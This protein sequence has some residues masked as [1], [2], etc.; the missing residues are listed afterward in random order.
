MSDKID[1]F[2]LPGAW[3]SGT[4]F[5]FMVSVFS[6]HPKV[7]KIHVLNYDFLSEEIPSVTDRAIKLLQDINN[8]AVVVGH[9]LGGIIALNIS[10][11]ENVQGILTISSPLAGIKMNPLIMIYLNHY[12]PKFNEIVEKSNI[13]KDIHNKEYTKPM[14]MLVSTVGFNPFIFEPNDGIVT[15]ISQTKWKPENA[16]MKMIGASHHEILQHSDTIVEL[17]RL[18]H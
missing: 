10:N 18:L 7:D 11:H 8:K 6:K 2:L 14:T 1:L 12:I 13:I 16:R 5:N 17:G 15:V 4:S 3:S 9:S